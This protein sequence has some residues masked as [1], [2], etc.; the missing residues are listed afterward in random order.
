MLL[1]FYAVI[2]AGGSGTRLW[3]LSRMARPKQVLSLIGS[4]SLFQIAIDRLLPWLPPEQIL[5]VTTVAVA[6]QLSD[7]VPEIPAQNFVLEP[8]GR[9]TAPVIGLGAVIA[10]R[11][12][13]E[14]AIIG[15]LTADHFI[16]DTEKFLKV[17]QVA[18]ES[19]EDGKI[20][21]LG[22]QP[23]FASTG[24]GYI[25]RGDLQ[26]TVDGLDVF[27]AVRFKEK[28][29]QET[30][31]Q[32]VEDGRHAWNS[33]MFIWKT[34][35]VRAE[36]KR[37]LPGTYRFLEDIEVSLGTEREQETIA[38][39]WPQIERETIDFGIMEDAENVA[40]IPVDIGWS[41]VGNWASLL[42]ILPSDEHGNV[43][44]DAKHYAIDTENT[45]IHSERL[46]ATIGLRDT[47]IVDT[48][49][50]LLVCAA[51]SSQDVRLVVEQLQ[52]NGKNYL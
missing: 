24:F 17:L 36:F 15:C 11:L 35:R 28:P 2:M 9:G 32:Y 46:V 23:T 43:V 27:E 5:V 18:A 44:L 49:D 13:G 52:Q 10:E 26:Q 8:E 38:Q 31:R 14:E 37:Q 16:Q 3:P 4:R 19:A 21:T 1:P 50:A 51:D 39:L 12:A 45:L 30:A 41:D 7:Q 20:V 47:I 40:V 25:E 34:S 6:A 29:N 33:G 42:D 22:I 48:E